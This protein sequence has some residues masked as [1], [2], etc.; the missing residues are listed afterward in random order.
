MEVGDVQKTGNAEKGGVIFKVNNWK[1]DPKIWPHDE[2]Y[3]IYEMTYG[4]QQIFNFL[5][6]GISAEPIN[7]LAQ[8]VTNG[9]YFLGVACEDK[10]VCNFDA[11]SP[12]PSH[13]YRNMLEYT[14]AKSV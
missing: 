11:A 4:E 5:E 14:P 10:S 9:R 8:A 1:A 13:I 2:M 3:G 12:I 6:L 7:S